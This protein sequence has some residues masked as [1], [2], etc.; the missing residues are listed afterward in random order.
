M[1]TPAKRKGQ[2]WDTGTLGQTGTP[3]DARGKS[4]ARPKRT[5]WG[6]RTDN[7]GPD[8]RVHLTEDDM[9][10]SGIQFSSLD[11]KAIRHC[12]RALDTECTLK[13]V[14]GIVINELLSGGLELYRKGFVL[15]DQ[16]RHFYV[17]AWSQFVR[18]LLRSMWSTGIAI[19]TTEAHEVFKAIPHVLDLSQLAVRFSSDR[20]GIRHYIVYDPSTNAWTSAFDG[21]FK[22]ASVGAFGQGAPLS[23]LQVFEMD[24]PHPSGTLQSKVWSLLPLVELQ[25]SQLASDSDVL[26]QR[27]KPHAFLVESAEYNRYYNAQLSQAPGINPSLAT[28]EPGFPYTT[29]DDARS[30]SRVLGHRTSAA[31]RVIETP[32]Y[33]FQRIDEGLEVVFAPTQE[34][35]RHLEIVLNIVEERV[36]AAFGVPR[37]MFSRTHA[38]LRTATAESAAQT[39]FK[40]TLR[41]LKNVIIPIMNTVFLSIYRSDFQRDTALVALSDNIANEADLTDASVS[42]NFP[43]SP[44]IDVITQLYRE[45]VL[46]RRFYIETLSHKYCIPLNQFEPTEIITRR[47][48][49]GLMEEPGAAETGTGESSKRSHPSLIQPMYKVVHSPYEPSGGTQK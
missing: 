1:S 6:P 15:T 7:N 26:S 24:P 30:R 17:N 45:G 5:R 16:A 23:G 32:H 37:S 39:L 42:W 43:G 33:R 46:T 41:A 2:T 12:M 35:P 9:V 21:T 19:V 27:R 11:I 28:L 4:T 20:Y 38:S 34:E 13:T 47:E 10:N 29:A 18:Q 44:D 49:A 40:D 25:Y 3:Q 31:S 36:G 22:G 8:R 48:L 14:S